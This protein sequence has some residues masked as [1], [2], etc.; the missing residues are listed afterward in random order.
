MSPGYYIHLSGFILANVRSFRRLLVYQSQLTFS[1]F[2]PE[3]LP[4]ASQLAFQELFLKL[5][6]NLIVDSRLLELDHL[7]PDNA[8]LLD[9]FP[10]E[11]SAERIRN[12]LLD[13]FAKTF[14]GFANTG[15]AL[16]TVEKP[17][18]G[19]DRVLWINGLWGFSRRAKESVDVD[20]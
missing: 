1:Y 3:I 18:K 20:P 15:C 12:M 13:N 11:I 14:G 10:V 17:L 6:Q 9:R 16:G 5:P 8:Q 7:C 4:L 19:R 2:I